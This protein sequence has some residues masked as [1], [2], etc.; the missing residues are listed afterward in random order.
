MEK[1]LPEPYP[2]ESLYSV[3]CRYHVRS[4]NKP[5]RTSFELFGTSYVNLSASVLSPREFQRP[6]GL[7]SEQTSFE[8]SRLIK[9]HTAYQ[10]ISTSYVVRTDLEAFPSLWN[11]EEYGSK[12]K[13]G[14]AKNNNRLCYCTECVREELNHY[15][16]PYWHTLHQL[17]GVQYCPIHHIPL[18]ESNIE[19]FSSKPNQY[20]PAFIHA[21][22]GQPICEASDKNHQ[23]TISND[24]NWF[25]H[26]G[27]KL[28]GQYALVN[29]YIRSLYLESSYYR[30]YQ[31]PFCNVTRLRFMNNTQLN[32]VIAEELQRMPGLHFTRRVQRTSSLPY[33]YSFG[34]QQHVAYIRNRFGGPQAYLDQCPV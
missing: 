18:S 17:E 25:L 23:M 15:G 19:I 2:G 28:G 16:E 31:L 7:L 12:K 13:T 24:F 4:G 8:R 27:L 30:R 9:G 33:F 14:I 21:H 34:P 10:L 6:Y 32:C 5:R 1:R 26:N 29:G 11:V 20:H 3:F 22:G